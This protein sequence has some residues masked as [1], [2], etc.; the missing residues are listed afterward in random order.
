M[1]VEE[2]STAST[3]EVNV[4]LTDEDQFV[5]IAHAV[6]PVAVP[7]P[8]RHDETYILV[9]PDRLRRK[10]ADIRCNLDIHRGGLVLGWTIIIWCFQLVEGQVRQSAAAA[11][12]YSFAVAIDLP[13]SGRPISARKEDPQRRWTFANP[14]AD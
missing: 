10:L 14:I 1:P 12:S 6:A 5:R 4:S 8:G 7:G 13:V 3:T 2:P 9:I 11:L